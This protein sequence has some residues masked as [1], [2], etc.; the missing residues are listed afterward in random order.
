VTCLLNGK[1]PIFRPSKVKKNP[2]PIDI[3]DRG[4]YVGNLTPHANIGISTIKRGVKV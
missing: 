1:T 4:D 2:E 3:I